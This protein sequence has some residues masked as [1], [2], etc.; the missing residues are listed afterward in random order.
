MIATYIAEAQP[1]WENGASTFWVVIAVG[2][3]GSLIVGA[4]RRPR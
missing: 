2:V 4:F 3:A 1:F